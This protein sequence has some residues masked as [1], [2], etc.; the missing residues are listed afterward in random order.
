[1]S[2]TCLKALVCAVLANLSAG[3]VVLPCWLGWLPRLALLASWLAALLCLASLANDGSESILLAWRMMEANPLYNVSHV[4]VS[5]RMCS[6]CE[7]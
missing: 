5:T 2:H 4:S 1:M 3:R 7:P 6:A